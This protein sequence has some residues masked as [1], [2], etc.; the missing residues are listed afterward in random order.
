MRKI[1]LF[2]ASLLS[3][4]A[5]AQQRTEINL[6]D[7]WEFSRDSIHWEQVTV[8][9][10]WAIAGPF[11]KKWD[12]QFVAIEQNGEK[13]KTEKSGRS[14]SLP[15]IGKGFYRTTVRLDEVPASAFLCFDGAM[16]EPVVYV[17][18]RIAGRWAYGYNAF[19]MDVARLLRKGDNRIAVTLQN[20]EESSRWY[21]GG[22]IYRPVTLI[23]A[24][25]GMLNDW[26]TYFRTVDIHDDTA[27][28]EVG[29]GA[30][31]DYT[32]GLVAAE[33]TLRDDK[34]R[35]VAACHSALDA[36]G[37]FKDRIHLRKAKLWSPE[38]PYLYTLETTLYRDLQVIDRKEIKVGVRTIQVAAP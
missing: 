13:E 2:I 33:I 31:G 30:V 32:T 35:V 21:P 34:G 11:D 5:A 22:G 18:G 1:L 19:R 6:S 14:G 26:A 20:V 10:D 23:V 12:L 28:I 4:S 25:K 37:K 36:D 7:Q 16:S 9:H 24:G 8:P 15:W 29:C 38:T 17:N 27:E 3:L